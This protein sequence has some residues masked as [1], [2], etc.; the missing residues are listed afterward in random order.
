MH[1]EEKTL[2]QF[3][4]TIN[5]I[6]DKT[7]RHQFRKQLIE[8]EISSAQL[9]GCSVFTGNRLYHTAVIASPDL[10]SPFKLRQ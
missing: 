10:F 3:W 9:M 2:Q 5:K 7:I 1:S 4:T 8:K 6:R